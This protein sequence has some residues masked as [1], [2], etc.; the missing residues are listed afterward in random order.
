MPF[1]SARIRLGAP[2]F[3]VVGRGRDGD[4]GSQTPL[5]RAAQLDVA[6]TGK[7]FQRRSARMEIGAYDGKNAWRTVAPVNGSSQIDTPM[8]PAL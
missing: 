5:G 8:R 4:L 6:A 3:G 2:D 7:S 1:G